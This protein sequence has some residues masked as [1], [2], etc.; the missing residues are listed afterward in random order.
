ML[1]SNISNEVISDRINEAKMVVF[2]GKN[3]QII[4]Y[5]NRQIVLV[6]RPQMQQLATGEKIK[7]LFDP[8]K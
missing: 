3:E 2:T 4:E 7:G 6:E 8:M 1:F 5:D